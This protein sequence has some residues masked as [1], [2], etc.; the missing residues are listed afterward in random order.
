MPA[1][2]NVLV[3]G[4]GL[5]GA[6]TAIHLAQAGVAVDLVEIKP[7]VAALGSGITLQ[8]NALRELRSLGVWEQVQAAGFAFDVT[9]IRAPDPNGTVVAEIPDAKTGGPDLPAVMGMPR[10]ALARI[11]VDRA[12]EVGVKLRLGTTFT[13]LSQDDDGVDVA[14]SDTSTGRYDLV[15]GADGVRSWTR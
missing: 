6:A 4:G 2:N 15:V 9:G 7:D 3:V 10:P 1:V 8:G 14:F 11:L 13:E 12:T 5:A